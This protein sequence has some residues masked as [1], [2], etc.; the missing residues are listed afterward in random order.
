MQMNE[1]FKALLATSLSYSTRLL[2]SN[3]SQRDTWIAYFSVY[4]P[5]MTYTLPVSHHAPKRLKKLQSKATRA[6]LMKLGFN[7]NTARRVVYG[8]ARYGGLGFRDLAVEQGIAQ[9][10]LFIRHT[11]AGSSQ[12]KLLRIAL[13]WWQLVIGV[14]YPLLEYQLQASHTRAHIC[15]PPCAISY[16]I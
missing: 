7:R 14:S 1:A 2:C 5:S 8:P 9:V 15:F 11:R 13:S 4:I 16:Q 3:L 6:T 10:E 12:G